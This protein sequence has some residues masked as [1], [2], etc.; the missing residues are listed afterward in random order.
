LLTYLLIA[1]VQLDGCNV[2]GYTAWS[3]MDNFEWARGYSE[4]FGLYQ[5]DFTDPAR[6]R[7]AKDSVAYF[8]KLIADNG[9]PQKN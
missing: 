7:T 8:K 9:W 3:L 6:P 1:A 2:V 4:T 5:V